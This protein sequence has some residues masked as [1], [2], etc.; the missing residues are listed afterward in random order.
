[1]H[2]DRGPFVS[3]TDEKMRGVGET[4]ST[5]RISSRAMPRRRYRSC[6]TTSETNVHWNQSVR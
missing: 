2:T 4:A 1:M 3:S 6:T 5:D